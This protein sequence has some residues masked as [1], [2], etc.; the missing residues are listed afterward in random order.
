MIAAIILVES[1]V[2]CAF[3]VLILAL[4]SLWRPGRLA[5]SRAA[6]LSSA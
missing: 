5:C 4:R 3:D 6:V 2:S 1:V